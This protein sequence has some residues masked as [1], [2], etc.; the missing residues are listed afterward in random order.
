MKRMFQLCERL[1]EVQKREEEL[2]AS[3][4]RIIG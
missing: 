3:R 4:N 2:G 1:T